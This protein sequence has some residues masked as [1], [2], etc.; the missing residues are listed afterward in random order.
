MEHTALGVV[1]A[2]EAPLV[3]REEQKETDI[4]GAEDGVVR[5]EDNPR[6]ECKREGLSSRPAKKAKV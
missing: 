3:E 1:V 2:E 4:D 5:G 6:I